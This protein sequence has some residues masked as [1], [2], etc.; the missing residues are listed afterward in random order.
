MFESYEN[1]LFNAYSEEVTEQ[2]QFEGWVEEME[3]FATEEIED[4]ILP[5]PEEELNEFGDNIPF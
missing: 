2:E 5:L 1:S 4:F 3:D